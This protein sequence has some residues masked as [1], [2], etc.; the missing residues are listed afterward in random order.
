MAHDFDK[1]LPLRSIPTSKY[2]SIQKS[3]GVDDPDM[4]PMWVADM[5]F[6]AA[7]G[8]LAAVQREVDAGYFGY[9]GD[10]S[11]V[12]GSVARWYRDRHGWDLDPRWVR[13]THGVV[14]AFGDVLA[15]FSEPGDG[16][17]TFS[18]V[19]HA[20]FRQIEAMERTVVESQLVL[21]DGQYHMDLDALQDSLSG[22]EKILTF[23]T[24]HNPGGRIWSADEIR[25]VVA[26]G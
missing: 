23:C 19:Y 22:R 10:V 16:V 5:D 4:I 3:Y 1:E 25:A 13:F 12:S 2:G 18:P 6:A 9:Y 8:I 21:R 11:R 7:P 26:F 20:F 17:I 14:N 24:P 15:A